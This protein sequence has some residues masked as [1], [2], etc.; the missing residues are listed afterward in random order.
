MLHL[1]VYAKTLLPVVDYPRTASKPFLIFSN[2]LNHGLSMQV[3][4]KHAV[5]GRILFCSGKTGAMSFYSFLCCFASCNATLQFAS[6]S[7]QCIC[8]GC[9]Q[10][11]EM[12]ES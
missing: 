10:M 7:C 2:V 12:K 5:E 4:I 3:L 1:I 8:Q 9:E 11:L 6:H